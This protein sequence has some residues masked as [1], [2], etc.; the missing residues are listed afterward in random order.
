MVGK[1]ILLKF[2]KMTGGFLKSK[3]EFSSLPSLV[4]YRISTFADFRWWSRLQLKRRIY[5]LILILGHIGPI[6]FC[7]RWVGGPE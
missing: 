6:L 5:L 4:F 1:G 3:I 7:R 2:F